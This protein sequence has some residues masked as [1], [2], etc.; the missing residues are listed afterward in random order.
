MTA[1]VG[2]FSVSVLDRKFRDDETSSPVLVQQPPFMFWMGRVLLQLQSLLSMV[3]G[4]AVAGQ[5]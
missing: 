1:L 5:N 4:S 3:K 2:V